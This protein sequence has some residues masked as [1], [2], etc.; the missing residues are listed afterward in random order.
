MARKCP[1][2]EPKICPS[3]KLSYPGDSPAHSGLAGGVGTGSG[4]V[5]DTQPEGF[6]EERGRG[7]VVFQSDSGT[8]PEELGKVVARH[9][10]RAEWAFWRLPSVSASRPGRTLHCPS[11]PEPCALFPPVCF[12]G[13][14]LRS[15]LR[16][17]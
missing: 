1:R 3:L 4:V 7:L 17:K 16:L 14:P 13:L 5:S 11:R 10:T 12:P 8:Q 6:E 9:L 2:V 15:S